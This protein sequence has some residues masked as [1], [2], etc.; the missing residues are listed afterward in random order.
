MGMKSLA[1]QF[2]HSA[3]LLAA[4]TGT[5]LAEPPPHQW[6]LPKYLREASGLDVISEHMLLAHNDEKGKIYRLD[7]E[8]ETVAQVAAIGKPAIRDDFEG[9]AADGSRVFLITSK[10]MLYI[11]EEP[12]VL[13]PATTEKHIVNA[14]RVSTGAGRYCE[15][16]GLHYEAG[17]LLLPCKTVLTP[18]DKGHLIV[19][20]YEL[21]SGRL[22]TLIKIP[23]PSI[24]GIKKLNLTAI[25]ATDNHYYIVAANRLVLIDKQSRQTR[26]F[27]LKKSLHQQVEG[28]AVMPDGSFVLVED[29]RDGISRVSQYQS[30][31]QLEEKGID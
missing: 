13:S 7:L 27:K 17:I 19:L 20:A 1:R 23:K 4:F 18:G 25:D 16:E 31:D 28:L 30:L 3:L 21:N 11:I 26:T 24:P 22:S 15:I 9:I 14:K 29:N 12:A 10:G 5:L 8:T 6:A 2:R